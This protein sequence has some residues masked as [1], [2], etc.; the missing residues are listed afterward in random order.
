[1]LASRYPAPVVDRCVQLGVTDT[2]RDAIVVDTLAVSVVPS[3]AVSIYELLKAYMV[4][5]SGFTT[6]D[7]DHCFERVCSWF[8]ASSVAFK[9][10]TLGNWKKLYAAPKWRAAP[11]DFWEEDKEGIA[12]LLNNAVP[13]YEH[14]QHAHTGQH[15]CTLRVLTAAMAAIHAG[16]AGP[17]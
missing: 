7:A 10:R 11:P 3:D 16:S 4:P 12:E 13:V 17:T 1:M 15:I 6:T 9:A 14:Q 8:I 2:Q 5:G